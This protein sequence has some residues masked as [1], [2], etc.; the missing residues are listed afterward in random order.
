MQPGLLRRP[1]GA[2]RNDEAT[3]RWLRCALR[4]SF[5]AFSRASLARISDK[6]NCT[7]LSNTYC[8]GRW[9]E[10]SISGAI[11]PSVRTP[12]Q[13][14]NKDSTYSIEKLSSQNPEMFPLWP[15][16]HQLNASINY[17][18]RWEFLFS[19]DVWGHA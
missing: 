1:V 14:I 19:N 18:P 6:R 2:P 17:T 16:D 11:G 5:A 13:P 8:A 7:W 4:H 3:P 15:Y 9:L 10:R 12:R